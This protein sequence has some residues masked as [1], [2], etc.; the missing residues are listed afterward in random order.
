MLSRCE[1]VIS[2]CGTA[3]ILQSDPF[4]FIALFTVFQRLQP[5]YARLK[6][7]TAVNMYLYELIV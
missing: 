3:E 6:N 2:L 1:T 4:T 5:I 7:V